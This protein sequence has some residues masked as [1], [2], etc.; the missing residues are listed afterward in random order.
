MIFISNTKAF[1]QSTSLP[2]SL[3]LKLISYK[4]SSSHLSS[5]HSELQRPGGR[6]QRPGHQDAGLREDRPCEEPR[7]RAREREPPWCMA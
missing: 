1:V 7:I 2:K 6:D 5:R 3:R 4:K